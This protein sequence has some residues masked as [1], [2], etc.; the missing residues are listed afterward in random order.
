M[1]HDTRVTRAR[2]RH[3]RVSLPRLGLVHGF[4]AQRFAERSGIEPFSHPCS[5]CGT[6][7][8]TSIPFVEGAKRGLAAPPCHCGDGGNMYSIILEDFSR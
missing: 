2:R 1:T 7:R 4:N 8:T 6:M 3:K 5:G